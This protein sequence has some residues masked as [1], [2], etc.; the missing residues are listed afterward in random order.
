MSENKLIV[1]TKRYETNIKTLAKLE[2]Q[3][4]KGQYSYFAGTLCIDV[5]DLINDHKYVTVDVKAIETITDP[6]EK[7]IQYYA[8]K[9][10]EKYKGPRCSYYEQAVSNINRYNAEK[11]YE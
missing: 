7:E 8:S 1:E 6:L 11:C 9:M 3:F 4:E 5:P 10:Y 2:D